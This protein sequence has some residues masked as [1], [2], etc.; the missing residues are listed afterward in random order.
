MRYSPFQWFVTLLGIALVASGCEQPDAAPVTTDMHEDFIHDHEHVHGQG[1]DHEHEHSGGHAGRHSHPHEH[2]HRHGE[3][4]HGGRIVSIGHTH[5]RD[6][7]T[8]Y[9][10]EVMPLT[11]GV[12]SF[13][14]LTESTEGETQEFPIDA[15]EITG[16]IAEQAGDS[17]QAAHGQEVKFTVDAAIDSAEFRRR[18]A[19]GARPGRAAIN[20][21]PQGR[22]RRRTLQFQLS[23]VM[24]GVH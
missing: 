5:H 22:P 1:H 17:N 9:H 13:Y 18:S 10:A 6:G 16:Y 15:Q 20:R 8:H 7:E 14:I 19:R 21:R 3:P 11:G 24:R 12:I 4:L 23:S 2:S